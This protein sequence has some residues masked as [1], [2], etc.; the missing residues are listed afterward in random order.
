MKRIKLKKL[1]YL[2]LAV[3]I[4]LA[5]IGYRGYM[6]KVRN[7][8][9]NDV[10][11][12]EIEA[13]EYVGEY[14]TKLGSAKVKVTVKDHQIIRVDILE[15]NHVQGKKAE[16]VIYSVIEEQTPNVDAIAGATGSSK[17]VCKAIE[18][19]LSNQK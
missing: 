16:K 11:L 10:N 15:H 5:T 12:T 9:I 14:A 19:A 6:R 8:E 17:V 3:V 1:I 18:N 13:G 2:S 4:I 7:I